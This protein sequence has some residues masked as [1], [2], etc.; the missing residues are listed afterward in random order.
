MK[1]TKEEK[2]LAVAKKIKEAD[3]KLTTEYYYKTKLERSTT[4][5]LDLYNPIFFKY[6]RHLME[7]GKPIS[8]A[9]M[10]DEDMSV[11]ALAYRIYNGKDDKYKVLKPEDVSEDMLDEMLAVKD[12]GEVV[13]AKMTKKSIEYTYNDY[14]AKKKEEVAKESERKAQ[15]K[16]AKPDKWDNFNLVLSLITLGISITILIIKICRFS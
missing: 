15:A 12:V 4:E 8:L 3:N 2:Y 1:T 16:N 7:E 9:L 14:L 11:F 6:N 5:M 13:Q 10:T